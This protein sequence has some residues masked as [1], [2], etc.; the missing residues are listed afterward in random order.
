MTADDLSSPPEGKL[1]RSAR[2][3]AIPKLSIRAAAARIGISPEHWGNIERGY[4]SS[5]AAGEPRRLDISPA[6]I[7]KMARAVGVSPEL[8]ETEGERPDAAAELRQIIRDGTPAMPPAPPPRPAR[9][10]HQEID[11]SRGERPALQPFI[12]LILKDAYT[13]AGIIDRLP[14]GPLPDPW[15]IPGIPDAEDGVTAIPGLALFPDSPRDQKTWDSVTLSMRQ[16]LD[17]IAWGHRLAAEHDERERRTGLTAG[18]DSVTGT[19]HGLVSVAGRSA[20]A[21]S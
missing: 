2:E 13:L 18:Q 20:R 12:A 1:I 17:L 14:P 19:V 6:L 10:A 8:L 9:P 5:G 11:F 4:K 16:K 7:A 3:R 21:S 15:D